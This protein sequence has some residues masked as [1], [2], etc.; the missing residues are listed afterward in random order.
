MLYVSCPEY[1]TKSKL[2]RGKARGD[3]ILRRVR[4]TVVIVQR[5]QLLRTLCVCV[6][7]CVSV[8]V[9]L[10][11]QHVKRLPPPYYIVICGPSDSTIFF[12]IIIN[13]MIF[14]K[15]VIEQKIVLLQILTKTFFI[16]TQI[17]PNIIINILRFSCKVLGYHCHSLIKLEFH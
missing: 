13:G 16:A 8:C 1:K 7:V 11:I 2:T 4:E 3:V 14:G 12:D 10:V 6:C 17:L 9:A 15:K 5:Q